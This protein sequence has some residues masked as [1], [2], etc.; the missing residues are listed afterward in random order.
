MALTS[1]RFETIFSKELGKRE[2]AA[3]LHSVT[4]VAMACV[5]SWD[6]T[7]TAGL[8]CQVCNFDTKE[9]SWTCNLGCGVRL[10]GSCM[11]KWKSKVNPDVVGVVG[12]P[13]P[14]KLQRAESDTTMRKIAAALR[15]ACPSLADA[16]E[17]MGPDVLAASFCASAADENLETK[18]H[19]TALLVEVL[20]DFNLTL[21]DDDNEGAAKRVVNGLVEKGILN[22]QERA[23]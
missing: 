11:F 6:N 1:K 19:W 20:S 22:A 15:S 14:L 12:P 8:R 4:K 3:G 17:E 21:D 2:R 7:G 18:E 16:G 9:R 23:H 13:M 10:C 5:H